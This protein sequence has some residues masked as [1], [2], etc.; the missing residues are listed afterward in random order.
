MGAGDPRNPDQPGQSVDLTLATTGASQGFPRGHP[1]GCRVT[2]F[3]AEQREGRP[4]LR[5]MGEVHRFKGSSVKY[6]Q[7]LAN[8]PDR[9]VRGKEVSYAE[10]RKRK[11]TTG[12]KEMKTS[13]I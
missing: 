13:W 2:S 5:D 1:P 7:Q 4:G 11:I 8:Q 6:N 12:G 3:T 10:R 9:E